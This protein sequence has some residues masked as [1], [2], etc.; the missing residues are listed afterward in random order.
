MTQAKKGLKLISIP[1]RKFSSF[2]NEGNK[3]KILKKIDVF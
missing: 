1:R 2:E 3:G